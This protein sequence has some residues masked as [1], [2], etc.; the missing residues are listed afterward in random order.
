MLEEAKLTFPG[1]YE[2][3]P[4][5]AE[6]AG[7]AARAAGMDGPTIYAI[8][9]AIDE[10][11]SNIIEHAYGG[12]GVGSIHCSYR[13]GKTGLKFILRDTGSP[14]DPS[15]IP[16]PDLSPQIES[17]HIGGLGLYLIHKIMD[18]VHFEFAESG[19]TLTLTKHTIPSA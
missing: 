2:S 19:N 7:Q 4:A 15:A 18:E 16:D 5:I 17:R 3:L 11:C 1:Q 14:F 10:A 9:L 6:F 8:Q 12:E 13:V